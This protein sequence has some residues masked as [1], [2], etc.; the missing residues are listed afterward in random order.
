M[1]GGQADGRMDGSIEDIY[2]GDILLADIFSKDI[3]TFSKWVQLELFSY[4]RREKTQFTKS[5][6]G[7]RRNLK[8][9]IWMIKKLLLKRVYQTDFTKLVTDFIYTS[10]ALAR[11]IQ[12]HLSLVS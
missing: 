4:F 10:F 12:R 9:Y 3:L 1:T 2:C 6:M 7:N 5:H 8:H 11:E